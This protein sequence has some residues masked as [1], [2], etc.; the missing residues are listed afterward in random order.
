[1]SVLIRALSAVLV[2]LTVS[3]VVVRGQ[4]VPDLCTQVTGLGYPCEH[5]IIV[6]A[7]GFQLDTIRIPP[8]QT[9]AYP[10][11][12]Q[13]GL[14]DSAV[15]WVMNYYPS[16]NLGCLLHDAGYDVW[17][18]NS[19]G[20]I[21][22]MGNA[23]LSQWSDAYWD[24][25]DMDFMAKYDLPA[26]IDYVT[27]FTAHKT[28]SW[29]GH[30]QGTWQAFSAFSDV[31]RQYAAKVDVFV[32]LAPVAFVAHQ[33]SI[34]LAILADL[35][36]DGIMAIFGTHEFLANDWLIHAI[37]AACAEAGMDCDNVLAI[38]CGGANMTNINSTQMY[39]L[40]NYDPGGTSV[41]NMIHW[42]QEVRTKTYQMHDWGIWNPN[43][44]N[45]STTV[46]SYHLANYAGPKVALFWG[47]GDDLADPADVATIAATIPAQYIIG[48]MGLPGYG[49]LDFVWG[50]D[51]ATALYPNII[52]TIRANQK[53]ST[54][55]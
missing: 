36:V 29:V 44:Y 25:I 47:G 6:T 12:L 51:A 2:L 18:G 43:F 32:A 23:K 5:H 24:S 22:S 16:Q 33:E 3:C 13:H 38:L 10:V 41:S 28:L 8:K 49:H 54:G 17:M 15:T 40:T 31:N 20:N 30:S 14:L 35:D 55:F 4:S 7:D 9:G 1:M 48:N 46:P 34:L 27:N 26:N 42:A 52:S 11:F 53:N 39:Q 45:G 21:Y 37:S 50:L 19:R